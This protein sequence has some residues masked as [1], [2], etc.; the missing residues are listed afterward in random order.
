MPQLRRLFDFSKIPA[1]HPSCLGTPGDPNR[2]KVGFFK[3]ETKGNPITEF[4]ALKPKMYSFKV[5]E[6]QKFGSNAQPRVCDK[7]MG[8]G[9]ARATLKKTT[10]QQY[11]DMY[12]EREAT[13]VTNRRIASKLHQVFLIINYKLTYVNILLFKL[14][15]Y[16]L[17]VETR[18]LIAYD[19]KR[20]LLANLDN[21]EP[22]PNIHAYGH[23][24]LAN[25]VRVQDAEEQPGAGN[26]LQ[27][28][29]RAK[30]EEARL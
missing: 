20:V 25:E 29:S 2:G 3:D 4:V 22:N 17:A 18:G 24:S 16:S 14:T 23:Y 5:C 9:I 12:Q 7:Q 21:G 26:D 30:K 13:K 15:V 19:D 10:H 28:E 6:C 27:I 1:N 11:L 8:N